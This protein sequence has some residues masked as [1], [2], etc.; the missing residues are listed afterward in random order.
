MEQ[1]AAQLHAHAHAKH[2][3]STAHRHR[4]PHNS[5]R[6]PLQRS[7]G[8]AKRRAPFTPGCFHRRGFI[9]RIN[10]ENVELNGAA[11]VFTDPAT[12]VVAPPAGPLPHRL[13]AC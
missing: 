2:G 13:A 5:R 7:V 9:L 6:R 12:A 1:V 8:G 10:C 4:R 3:S 11:A